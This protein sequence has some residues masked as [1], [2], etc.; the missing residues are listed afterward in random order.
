M[1][2]KIRN[3]N[4]KRARTHGFRARMSCRGGRR[5]INRRRRIGK[6]QLTEV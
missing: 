3:S 6:K 1:R 2:T 5:I 4:L